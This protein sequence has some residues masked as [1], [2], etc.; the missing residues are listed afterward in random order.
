MSDPAA[1]VAARLK[2]FGDIYGAIAG[3]FWRVLELSSPPTAVSG[4]LNDGLERLRRTLV[5]G[6]AGGVPGAFTPPGAWGLPGFSIPG[7]AGASGSGNATPGSMAP[8]AEVVELWQKLAG[9]AAPD[10]AATAMPSPLPAFGWT[11]ER[12]ES[13]QRY[14]EA[15]AEHQQNLVRLSQVWSGL[16]TEAV[17][18]LS[19]RI[20]A[21]LERG[22]RYE[23]LR[24]V[25]DA[26]I[27]CAEEC[28]ARVAHGDSYAGLQA[29]LTNSLTA[30][31]EA[32]QAIVE[33]LARD[34]DLPT[35]AELNTV[36]R[37]LQA[38]RREVDALRRERVAA[39][40]APAA[41]TR[42]RKPSPS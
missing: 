27:D 32:G 21:R 22:E 15:L 17:D 18:L 20:R 30:V 41:K 19:Q 34:F 12:Q 16:L 3:E 39:A 1:D 31:R 23:N 37:R 28:W 35:R 26:W 8:G 6:L 33:R 11:R 13:F 9:F 7:M 36:H 25:Y 42:R 40:P 5:G 29:A 10:P 24:A 2:Q 38:L 4:A 14:Q